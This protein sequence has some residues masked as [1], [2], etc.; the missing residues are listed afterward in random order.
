MSSAPAWTNCRASA[1]MTGV[2][3]EEYRS[4]LRLFASG[5]TVVTVSARGGRHGMTASA[6]ASHSLEPP[7][8][9]VSMDK[10]SHTRELVLET[11]AFAVNVL[12]EGQDEIAK[13]FAISGPKP[14]EELGARDCA[15]WVTS[16]RRDPCVARVFHPPG[17]GSGRSRPGHRI[18]RGNRRR[19]DQTT[20][21]LRSRLPHAGLRSRSTPAETSGGTEPAGNSI[22]IRP[23][24][25]Q[26]VR[27]RGPSPR[28]T[29]TTVPR[30]S[31]K[32][33]SM[34]MRN[35]NVWTWRAPGRM[36]AWPGPSAG[37]P[38]RPRSRDTTVSARSARCAITLPFD[39]AT[40]SITED[41]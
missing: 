22:A 24:T 41:G 23:A 18:G 37:R 36:S 15:G 20:R 9:L 19:R 29:S 5:V 6:F 33:T 10:A 3:P 30:P 1:P 4:T 13:R 39:A 25:T 38:I 31:Q 14:F 7:L 11:G 8:I 26:R 32:T 34:G 2:G 16:P 35:P 21:L 27:R 17:R 40:I 12:S 28:T